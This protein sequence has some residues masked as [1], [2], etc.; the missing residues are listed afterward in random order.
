[1]CKATILRNDRECQDFLLRAGVGLLSGLIPESG[2]PVIRSVRFVTDSHYV[3]AFRF[4][5]YANAIQNGYMVLMLDRS[6]GEAEATRMWDENDRSFGVV[7]TP[8][9]PIENQLQLN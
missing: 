4:V 5:G 9:V 6:V 1:M 8:V 3:Q 7:P 2:C